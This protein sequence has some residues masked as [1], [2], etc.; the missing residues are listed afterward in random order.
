MRLA[1]V[2]VGDELLSGDVAD[3]NS[4]WLARALTAAGHRVVRA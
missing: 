3:A 1:L 4:P 2:A